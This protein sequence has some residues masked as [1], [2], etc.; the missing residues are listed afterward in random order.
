MSSFW[1]SNKQHYL[2]STAA[3]Q[4][5]SADP[6]WARS[7]GIMGLRFF[8]GKKWKTKRS[9]LIIKLDAMAVTIVMGIVSEMAAAN[10]CNR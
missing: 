4:S 10:D 8:S 7:N 5:L 9:Q 1:F 6:K 3:S 2:S